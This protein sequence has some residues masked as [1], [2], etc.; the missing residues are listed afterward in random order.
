M[1]AIITRGAASAKAFGWSGG[2]GPVPY[3]YPGTLTTAYF[4][5]DNVPSNTLRYLY[6]GNTVTSGTSL[7]ITMGTGSGAGNSIVGIFIKGSV[8]SNTS[9]YTYSSSVTASATA[10][11]GSGSGM[12]GTG[13]AGNATKAV[14]SVGSVSSPGGWLT[15]Y[16]YSSDVVALT[17]NTQNAGVVGYGFYGY[18]AGTSSFAIYA[19]GAGPTNDVRFKYDYSAD[20]V[21]LV[22]ASSA[23]NY[24]GTAVGNSTYGIFVLGYLSSGASNSTNKYTYSS[25][26]SA[27]STNLTANTYFGASGGGN[28]VGIIVLANSTTTTNVWTYSGDTVAAGTNL[29]GGNVNGAAGASNGTTG[30]NV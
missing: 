28:S 9:K 3:V 5:L 1:P 20:T 8:T 6:S 10:M 12:A 24:A 15:T 25:D 2:S 7:T 19:N 14:F 23:G 13:S 22:T 17:A 16:T 11:D 27:V 21:S 18:A 26:V 29:T 30:V 4:L